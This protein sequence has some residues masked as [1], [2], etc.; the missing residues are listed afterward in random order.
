MER[1]LKQKSSRGPNVPRTNPTARISCRSFFFPFPKA[2]LSASFFFP[3]ST[4]FLLH[5]PALLSHAPHFSFAIFS[6]FFALFQMQWAVQNPTKSS[7]WWAPLSLI[8]YNVHLSITNPACW[9]YVLLSGL[10]IWLVL[11]VA[12]TR[13]WVRVFWSLYW[14]FSGPKKSK[15]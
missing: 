7:A 9:V 1:A 3:F 11:W 12:R 15:L 5:P 6:S 13:L 14:N 2:S 10:L 8:I 4:F